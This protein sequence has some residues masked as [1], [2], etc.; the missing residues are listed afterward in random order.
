MFGL[1]RILAEDSAANMAV[2]ACCANVHNP[3]EAHHY[4]GCS[5]CPE[6]SG[7]QSS[8]CCHAW[9]LVKTWL[10]T[11]CGKSPGQCVSV[12]TDVKLGA[13]FW[14]RTMCEVLY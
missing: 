7:V 14:L 11:L 5:L 8:I 2:V 1:D 3:L 9:L 6:G 4:E 13:A 12:G 10:P